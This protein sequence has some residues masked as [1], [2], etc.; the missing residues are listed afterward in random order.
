M[1]LVNALAMEMPLSPIPVSLESIFQKFNKNV[2]LLN[3]LCKTEFVEKIE[4]DFVPINQ[5]T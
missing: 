3:N 2:M 5:R 1:E 4:I